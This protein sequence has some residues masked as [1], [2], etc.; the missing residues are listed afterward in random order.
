MKKIFI[1]S[2]CLFSLKIMAQNHS[3]K[4]TGSISG[5]HEIARLIR[6]RILIKDTTQLAVAAVNLYP[7]APISNYLSQTFVSFLEPSYFNEF[8]QDVSKIAYSKEALVYRD[9]YTLSSG[10]TVKEMKARILICDSINIQDV[11]ANGKVNITRKYKCDSVSTLEKITAID[12]YEAWYFNEKNKMI[13]K[14]V[15][16][17]QILKYNEEKKVYIPIF[18]ILKDEEAKKKF[19]SLSGN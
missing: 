10:L 16:A 9:E 2:V 17:Y 11:D 12:F 15:L 7:E 1:I 19:L 14:D 5:K 8:K 18:F 3:K 4:T 13:E 6:T